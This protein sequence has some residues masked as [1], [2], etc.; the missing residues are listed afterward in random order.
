MNLAV[1][2]LL[3]VQPYN[4]SQLRFTTPIIMRWGAF[5]RV[6]IG[7]NYFCY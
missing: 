4:Y 1:T 2:S 7:D 6:E 5:N 3:Y